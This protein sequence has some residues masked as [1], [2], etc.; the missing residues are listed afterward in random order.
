[1]TTMGTKQAKRLIMK[2]QDDELY[3][4]RRKELRHFL[5][6]RRMGLKQQTY[7]KF[8]AQKVNGRY[9]SELMDWEVNDILVALDKIENVIKEF[10][11]E[12]YR[13]D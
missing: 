3:Q 9:D 12:L 7:S 10:R 11:H 5:M 8:M 13:K 2:R 6:V 1:M 4:K